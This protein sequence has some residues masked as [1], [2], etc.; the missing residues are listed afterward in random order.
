M[1]SSPEIKFNY[2]LM[3]FRLLIFSYR[4]LLSINSKEAF[5]SITRNLTISSLPFLAEIIK[6]VL[7]Y[8]VKQSDTFAKDL[9]SDLLMIYLPLS[10]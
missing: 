10:S 3:F 5:F 1:K 8:K 6:A 9:Q 4:P 7:K 2:W